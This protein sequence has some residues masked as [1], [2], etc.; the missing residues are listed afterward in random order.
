[1]LQLR[2]SNIMINCRAQSTVHRFMQ[3]G[4]II[5]SAGIQIQARIAARGEL[6]ETEGK[7]I[8][9]IKSKNISHSLPGLNI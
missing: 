9:E 3:K 8:S 4:Y 2:V 5:Y 1:M 7:Y 6:T